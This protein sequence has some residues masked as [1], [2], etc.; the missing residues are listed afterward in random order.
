[1][2]EHSISYVRDNLEKIVAR[3]VAVKITRYG[4]T[5]GYYNPTKRLQEGKWE[6]ILK[7]PV[8]PAQTPYNPLEE[9][10]VDLE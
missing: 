2:L 9:R 7:E 3:G 1:M 8:K 6:T 4:M 10:V 5:V